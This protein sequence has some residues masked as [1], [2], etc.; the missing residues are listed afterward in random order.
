MAT[1]WC[2]R[3]YFYVINYLAIELNSI[4]CWL[5][6]ASHV[7]EWNSIIRWNSH[8]K[9]TLRS[10]LSSL[11]CTFDKENY[12]KSFKKKRNERGRERQGEE[13]GRKIE[14][15][16][17][18]AFL[19]SFRC[20]LLSQTQAY[21]CARK[22]QL[23]KL[24]F[25]FWLV[26][27]L[28]VRPARC[29]CCYCCCCRRRSGDTQFPSFNLF[30]RF[31]SLA[32][33]AMCLLW[34]HLKLLLTFAHT[35]TQLSPFSSSVVPYPDTKSL[36]ITAQHIAKCMRTLC[37]RSHR[38][39]KT[40]DFVCVDSE[41]KSVHCKF[42]PSKLAIFFF[43]CTRMFFATR[44]T[45]RQSTATEV[46]RSNG[47]R[48]RA[49]VTF[50]SSEQFHLLRSIFNHLSRCRTLDSFKSIK[51][52]KSTKFDNEFSLRPKRNWI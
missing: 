13:W 35:H 12:L 30:H 34:S 3:L 10:Y 1:K 38:V 48:A 24:M 25:T 20:V 11:H 43:I 42:H 16:C 31:V 45:E 51:K 44:P 22:S 46:Q 49:R 26:R 37:S 39:S 33:A 47:L 17:V 15:K 18:E 9:T 50:F 52:W 27:C 23:F 29:R 14:K 2:V 19:R 8:A 7:Q 40:C 41:K 6:A 28:R 36:A 32:I 4:E 5:V 21:A